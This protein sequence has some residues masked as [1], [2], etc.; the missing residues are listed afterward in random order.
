MEEMK[1]IEIRIFLGKDVI[2][3]ITDDDLVSAMAHLLR[4]EEV[5]KLHLQSVKLSSVFKYYDGM[6]TAYFKAQMKE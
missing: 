6:E 2:G 3:T 4:F 5:R 1:I